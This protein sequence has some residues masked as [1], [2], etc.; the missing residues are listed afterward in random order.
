M[1]TGGKESLVW[2]IVRVKTFSQIHRKGLLVLPAS[3]ATSNCHFWIFSLWDK[4]FG[5]AQS[6]SQIQTIWV[7]RLIGASM[8]PG[9][10]GGN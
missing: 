2:Q 4:G 10:L 5:A 7:N 3:W 9:I 6:H 1:N 8:R